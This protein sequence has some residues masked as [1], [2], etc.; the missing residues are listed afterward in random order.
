MNIII[1]GAGQV[2]YTVAEVLAPKND[3]MVV[4]YDDDAASRANSMLNVSLFKGNGTNP[5][6]LEEAIT[7]HRAEV[8]IATT[9]T[10]ESN[11]FI[12]IMAK[13]FNPDIKTVARITDPDYLFKTTDKVAEGIDHIFSP[14]LLTGNLISTLATLENAVEY[15]SI[16]SM[17]MGLATF[18]VSKEHTDIIGKVV[19]GLDLP[20]DVTVVAIYRGDDV[21]LE[22]ETTE[23]HEGD[24]I[25]VLG[26]HD[27]IHE[28]NRSMG[29]IREANEIFILGATTA[30]IHTA[31]LLQQ[32]KRYIKLVE[33]DHELCSKLTKQF[34]MTIIKGNFI[35]PHTLNMENVG[36]ADVVIA[37]GKTDEVNLLACLMCRKLGS[38]KII[39]RYSVNEYEDI[40]DF[41]GIQSTIG[42][43]RVVANEII[44]TLVSDEDAILKM[45]HEGELFF[46]LNVNE[47]SDVCD[48]RLGDIPLPPGCRVACII[49]EGK[50]IYP[51]MDTEYRNGDKVLMYTYNAKIQ[52]LEKMFKTRINHNL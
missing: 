23:L 20:K 48:E 36:R 22:A 34:S 7:R 25:C 46:S 9:S 5:K 47:Q 11:L 52:K 28:F 8:I 15:E 4:E 10:D 14:E 42:Y 33:P 32:K 35:D 27:G 19:I 12:C 37:L 51:R 29:I 40:F 38:K 1:V 44:K 30:G 45:K 50:Q 3:V 31:R 6:T 39:S 26:S 24:R 17:N 41:T 18:L 16:E 13:R 2:G 21:I 43:H 49:R